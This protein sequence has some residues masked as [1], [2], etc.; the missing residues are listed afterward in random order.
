MS[1]FN[2][3]YDIALVSVLLAAIIGGDPVAMTY[4]IGGP[5]KRVGPP[6]GGLLGVLGTS[7]KSS[8]RTL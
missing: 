7:H 5:D 3:G 2:L 8:E 6:L 1:V 4:S